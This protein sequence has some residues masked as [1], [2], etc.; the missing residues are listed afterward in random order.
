MALW[1]FVGTKSK[2]FAQA[3]HKMNGG[4][5][6][7]LARSTTIELSDGRAF[8]DWWGIQ[9]NASDKEMVVRGKCEERLKQAFCQQALLEEE[10]NIQVINCVQSASSLCTI[11]F[12]CKKWLSVLKQKMKMLQQAFS[13]NPK[14]CQWLLS[15]LQLL[16]I[17]SKMVV[18]SC[19]RVDPN[20]INQDSESVE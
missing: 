13:H 4:T 16:Q 18:Q 11:Q 14:I 20:Q 6:S 3:L 10:V 1:L 15:V 9:W 12:C 17:R 5:K 8:S 2:A 7:A 19:G